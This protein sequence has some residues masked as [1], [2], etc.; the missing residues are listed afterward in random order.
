[1][2][3]DSRGAVGLAS[4]DD[5]DCPCDRKTGSCCGGMLSSIRL[6]ID[7]LE[8]IEIDSK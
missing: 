2:D 4:K 5:V 7:I 1:M 8:T 3:R 6:K